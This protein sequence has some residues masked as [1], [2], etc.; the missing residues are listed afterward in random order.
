MWLCDYH[1]YIN[2]KLDKDLED[3]MN[4]AVLWGRD[5]CDCDVKDDDDEDMD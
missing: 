3:C 5:E 2:E 1:N 4:V